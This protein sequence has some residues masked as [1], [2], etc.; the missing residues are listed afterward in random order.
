[1]LVRIINYAYSLFEVN[2]LIPLSDD[3]PSAAEN[4]GAKITHKLF[5]EVKF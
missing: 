3:A 2:L 1:M 5:G 4:E